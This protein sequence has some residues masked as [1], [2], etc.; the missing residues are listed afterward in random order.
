MSIFFHR[1]GTLTEDH[2]SRCRKLSKTH[3]RMSGGKD[4]VKQAARC[5]GKQPDTIASD[6]TDDLIVSHEGS[7]I[8]SRDTTVT[9][10]EVYSFGHKHR[11]SM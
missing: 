1:F 4:C 6:T 9:E 2:T 10:N 5:T 3:L 8:T 7:V 11:K